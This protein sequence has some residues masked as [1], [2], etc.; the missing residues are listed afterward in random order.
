MHLLI[1][2]QFTIQI[3][4]SGIRILSKEQAEVVEAYLSRLNEK[5]EDKFYADRE[6]LKD[7]YEL[8]Q[9]IC[10]KLFLYL[11]LR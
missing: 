7:T 6:T 9:L 10:K 8:W 11:I 3:S 2:I 4:F 5:T 1:H